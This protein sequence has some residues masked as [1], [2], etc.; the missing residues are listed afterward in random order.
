[1]VHSHSSSACANRSAL[2]MEGVF[3]PGAAAAFDILNY[4]TYSYYQPSNP[5]PDGVS[6]VGSGADDWKT[7]Y[8][9]EMMQKYDVAEK[10]LIN[11]VAKRRR[12]W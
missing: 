10:P 6:T 9:R 4:H 5:T 8:L 11:Y 7:R 1:M 2:F 12:I 3:A